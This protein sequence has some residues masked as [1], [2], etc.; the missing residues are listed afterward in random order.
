M[1]RMIPSAGR[2]MQSIHMKWVLAHTKPHPL[3]YTYQIRCS[4]HLQNIEW[5]WL[6]FLMWPWP[7]LKLAS[8]RQVNHGESHGI[9]ETRLAQTCK[10]APRRDVLQ[11]IGRHRRTASKGLVSGSCWGFWQTMA[12]P[13]NSPILTN[14][15]WW[16]TCAWRISKL[17]SECWEVNRRHRTGGSCWILVCSIWKVEFVCSIYQH[18]LQN[19][20]GGDFMDSHQKLSHQSRLYPEFPLALALD[21]APVPFFSSNSMDLGK[22]Y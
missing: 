9:S 6:V 19:H 15:V 11:P 14:G 17:T 10:A 18:C 8:W 4:I 16:N 21:P 22:F 12:N 13:E 7:A 2:S 20:R 5:F 1:P 3:P